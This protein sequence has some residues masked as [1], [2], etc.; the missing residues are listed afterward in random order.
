MLPLAPQLVVTAATVLAAWE[1]HR[2]VEVAEDDR[3]AADRVQSDASLRFVHF[4]GFWAQF[5]HH[6]PCSSWPLPRC[7]SIED[8]AE[9]AEHH[10]GLAA[11]P[12]AGDV[13]LLA[14]ADGERHVRA[15]IVA[16][17]ESVKTLP[18]GCPAFVCTTIEGELGAADT[19]EGARVTSVRL[20]RRRLSPAFG[21]Y[22]IRWCELLASS[23]RVVVKHETPA[24]LIALQRDRLEKAA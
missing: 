23:S 9:F 1:H 20:V 13:F 17:V 5:A 14:S 16:A 8:L 19:R 21:D 24:D 12:L 22:F 3:P 11:S 2:N 4:T 10:S 15:G 6:V 7:K 18:T